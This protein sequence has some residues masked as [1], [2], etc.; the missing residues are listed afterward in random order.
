M[1][2]KILIG[3]TMA[4]STSAFADNFKVIVKSDEVSYSIGSA[5]LPTGEI[6]C[7]TF[8][9]SENTVYKGTMFS[10]SQSNCKERFENEE[11]L[12]KFV[13]SPDKTENVEGSLVL[14][15]C[16]AIMNDGHSRGNDYYT[17]NT[18]GSDF[19]T[20][21]DMTTEG[22]GW[23][24]VGAM[25]DDGQDYWTWTNIN[26]LYNGNT[27]GDVRNLKQDYQN[28][29]WSTLIGNELLM[30][31]TTKS[32]Y[33][34]YN[35]LITNEPLKNEFFAA[36]TSSPE[37]TPSKKSGSWWFDPSCDSSGVGYMMTSAPD[38][39]GNGWLEGAKGFIWRS[40]NNN[41]CNYDDTSGSLNHAHPSTV[42]QELG[43]NGTTEFY[44][45]NFNDDALVLW[46]R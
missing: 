36:Q 25:A 1:K 12:E 2:H 27:T 6:T 14:S 15:S 18:N 13:D 5:F 29:A 8:S 45:L 43:W 24:L 40:V 41:A 26:Y 35:T 3:I 39:D 7:N 9:P 23:T 31:D 20:I 11:G 21:C 46:V 38:S 30:T 19:E 28:E 42:N 44:H 33:M 4:L 22:G 10:Q 17:I 16:L 34:I 32:K 37:Y